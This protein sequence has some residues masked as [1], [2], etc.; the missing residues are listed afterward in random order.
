ME[1]LSTRGRRGAARPGDRRDP[2]A[3]RLSRAG[4]AR[5]RRGGGARRAARLD[6][7]D[8]GPLPVADQDRRRRSACCW[9][10]STR[11]RTCARWRAST[12]AALASALASGAGRSARRG[13][14]RLHHR[15]RRRHVALPGRHRAGGPGPRARRAPLFRAL[16]ADPDAGAPRRR[17]ERDAARRRVARRRP[18]RAISA[19]IRP[20]GGARPISIPATR[21]EGA[22]RTSIAD[23]DDEWVEAKARA[24]TTEDH[25]L[26]D[27]TLV[28]RAAAVPPVQRA[29]RARLRA[30]AARDACRCSAERIDAML[31]SFSPEERRDDGRRRRHDRRHLR[32]LLDQADLRSRRLRR[33][34]AAR[35]AIHG[36]QRLR[37]PARR[38]RRD[39]RSRT[40]HAARPR[41]ARRRAGAARSACSRRCAT[42]SLGGG[43]RLRP[44]LVVETARAFGRDGRRA[45]PRR[46]GDRDACTPIRSIH[47]DLPAMDD[48]DLRRGRPTVHRAFDEATA[49]LAGDALLTLAFEILARPRDATGRRDPRRALRRPRPRQRPRRHGRRTDARHRRRK[50]RARRSGPRRSRC[51]RR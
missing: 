47:D 20:S 6:A 1:S 8:R 3:P 16:R 46:R 24:A 2:Q 38:G 35:L 30:D 11:R 22:A 9:S 26:I 29:R 34:N 14:P 51:C 43:K 4:R 28:E 49:I 10:I 15:S 23:E 33:L 42:A 45:A 32:V 12:Q 48:D 50:R 27:P 5:A 21:P 37:R 31:Q 39:D 36:R 41:A 13:P 7:Q 18:A 19:R 40:R 17:P 25:E 44:F